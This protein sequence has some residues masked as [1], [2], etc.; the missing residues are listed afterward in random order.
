MRVLRGTYE[1]TGREWA[2]ASQSC[3]WYS[4]VHGAQNS[5]KQTLKCHE[6]TSACTREVLIKSCSQG[7]GDTRQ[8][9]YDEPHHWMW[10]RRPAFNASRWCKHSRAN[11]ASTMTASHMYAGVQHTWQMCAAVCAPFALRC[12]W[13]GGR[14]WP[15]GW[16]RTPRAL[17]WP[18]SA[19][20]VLD[21]IMLDNWT[22]THAHSK[23]TL[24]K[25]ALCADAR[26]HVQMPDQMLI[27]TETTKDCT[28]GLWHQASRQTLNTHVCS[29]RRDIVNMARWTMA[30]AAS[31]QAPGKV[32][33]R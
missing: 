25:T 22:A 20:T 4:Q 10:E 11:S 1:Y 17:G 27:S 13:S 7:K 32:A 8:A 24:N 30:S 31:S 21:Q 2:R 14:I 18:A 16:G 19:K 12:P 6:T 29:R 28:L 15:A 26:P 9:Y 5:R 3:S 33:N 23:V